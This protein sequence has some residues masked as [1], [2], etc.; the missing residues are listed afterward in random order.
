MKRKYEHSTN[1]S[2]IVVDAINISTGGGLVLLK[3]LCDELIGNLMDFILVVDENKNTI[4]IDG[5][6]IVHCNNSLLS[7]YKF[8]ANLEKELQPSVVF[9]FGNFPPPLRL[10][11]RVYTYF[12]R[13]ALA[14]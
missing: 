8:Y 14:R 6:S 10:S 11:C 4:D 1:S 5:C 9:C 2:P 7:R 13:P 12:H 3:Y